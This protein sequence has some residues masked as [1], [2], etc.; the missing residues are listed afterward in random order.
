MK[1]RNDFIT[2]IQHL[3]G[4]KV[5]LTIVQITQETH[6]L[7]PI[8]YMMMGA[9]QTNLISKA[10]N[11]YKGQNG[12]QEIEA[13]MELINVDGGYRLIFIADNYECNCIEIFRPEPPMIIKGIDMSLWWSYHPLN[14]NEINQL[15]LLKDKYSPSNSTIEGDCHP[16]REVFVNGIRH[17]K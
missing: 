17:G 2:E 5:I 11:E 14:Q 12:V 7:G 4:K 9:E 10:D 3:N 6:P 16:I 1:L 15:D 13:E 8:G